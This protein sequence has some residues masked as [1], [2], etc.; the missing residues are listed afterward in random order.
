MQFGYL[1][2]KQI[3]KHLCNTAAGIKSPVSSRRNNKS[4]VLKNIK[5]D[6]MKMR[7]FYYYFH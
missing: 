1:K 3:D 2:Y 5:P 7:P 4:R 6:A